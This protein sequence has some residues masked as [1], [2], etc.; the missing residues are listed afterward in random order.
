MAAPIATSAAAAGRTPAATRRL[1]LWQ[2]KKGS[3]HWQPGIGHILDP[4]LRAN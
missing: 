1:L 3:V 2:I 4:W